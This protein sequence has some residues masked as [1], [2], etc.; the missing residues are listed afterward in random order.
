MIGRGMHER[1]VSMSAPFFK[2]PTD[3]W[4]SIICYQYREIP[5]ITSIPSKSVIVTSA[6]VVN[7]AKSETHFEK[8]SIAMKKRMI[9]TSEKIYLL[10]RKVFRTYSKK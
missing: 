5:H 6:E 7:I 2:M 1:Y 8:L 9:G 10:A 4:W 3:E